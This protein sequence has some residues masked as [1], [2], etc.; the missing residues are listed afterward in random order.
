MVTVFDSK[1]HGGNRSCHL[2]TIGSRNRVKGAYISASRRAGSGP[3]EKTAV[4]LAACSAIARENARLRSERDQPRA[5]LE[6]SVEREWL[7]R[8]LV[9]AEEERRRW[10][11]ELH[12]DTLQALGGLRVLLSSARRSSG[13]ASLHATL[14][15]AVDQLGDE[16][17][18]L[19]AL[20]T[21]LR[22][23]ALDELGLGPALEALSD[24]ARI[25][26]GLE[27]S[28][29]I[30]FD[31]GAGTGEARLDPDVETAIYRIVQESLTNAAK[32]ARADR[33][34][35]V[36][37]QREGDVEIAIRDDGRGFDVAAP[38]EGFGLTGIRERISLAGGRLE[39]VSS[40]SGTAVLAS[41]PSP[42]DHRV[43]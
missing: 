39:I 18:N 19:R 41:L 3:D 40:D 26:H 34:E 16:I 35:V 24:R 10:A 28:T 37:V 27:V 4:L 15:A 1:V 43:P 5:E 12:D 11:R 7:R 17:A 31:R 42:G 29:T 25:T 21:E 2:H 13:I 38:T 33:V 8:S 32:H 6:R 30:E 36:V 20:I 23:A 14:A 22:P 9:A